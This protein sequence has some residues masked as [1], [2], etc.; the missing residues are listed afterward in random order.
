MSEWNKVVHWCFGHGFWYANPLEEIKG[1]SEEELFWVPNPNSLCA[2]WHVGHIA[3]R[4]R[5]H[6][7]HFLQ[8][9]D[10]KDIIPP[11]FLVFGPEWHSVEEIRSSVDSVESVKIWM[12]EVREISHEYISSLKDTDFHLIPASSDENHSV[13]QVLFQTV[14]HG[15][16]HIGRI[17]MLRALIEYKKERAC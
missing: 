14:A 1:L 3:H 13:A 9:H 11:E 16:L 4:E 8:G 12:R 2:L 7:G 5:F 15:A 10:E 6:I 17:Q